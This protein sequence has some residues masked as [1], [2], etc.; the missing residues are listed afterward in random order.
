MTFIAQIDLTE[1]SPDI[2]GL[3]DEGR[4]LIF[5]DYGA[6]WIDDARAS[7]L[8]VWDRTPVGALARHDPPQALVWLEGLAQQ[9]W[10]DMTPGA[11][12]VAER[13]ARA[14]G[15]RGT[16]D[17]STGEDEA[18]SF[19][20]GFLPPEQPVEMRL[21]WQSLGGDTIEVT[22][23]RYATLQ[24]E[25]GAEDIYRDVGGLWPNERE[26]AQPPYHQVAGQPFP[27]QSDPR[28]DAYWQS[29]LGR[30]STQNG[31]FDAVREMIGLEGAA[32]ES[33]EVKQAAR[34]RLLLELDVPSF[35]DMDAEG[36][37]Y[38]FLHQDDLRAGRFAPV[39]VV[40]Q[41]T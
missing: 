22:Q 31:D 32:L 27:E 28:F 7:A 10:N 23:S 39:R 38:F 14:F 34:F 4:L 8:V 26:T 21:I 20:G 35:L 17:T 9:N 2:S 5:M 36:R 6:Y 12:S 3:P 13:M 25:T 1:L 24:A 29:L 18:E 37:F 16:R 40:Y 15:L 19:N 30:P 11:S 41:Q 33:H